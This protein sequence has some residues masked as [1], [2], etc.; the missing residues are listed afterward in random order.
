MIQTIASTHG[1]LCIRFHC[2]AMKRLRVDD[3]YMFIQHSLTTLTIR[4]C[5]EI[6]NP[7][8]D[9]PYMTFSTCPLSIR[10]PL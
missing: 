9:N 4:N 8:A 1:L 10:L 2:L 7:R 3:T 6:Y 5:T